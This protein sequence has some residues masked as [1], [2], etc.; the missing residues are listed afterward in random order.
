MLTIS[1]LQVA[2]FTYNSFSLEESGLDQ[3]SCSSLI[4]HPAR[5]SEV[6]RYLTYMFIHSGRFHLAFNI[7]A[8]LALGVPLEMVHGE[9]LSGPFSH[10]N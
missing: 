7:L 1:L 6:W 2:A 9:H 10:K 8:Q 3:P 4:F 5:R